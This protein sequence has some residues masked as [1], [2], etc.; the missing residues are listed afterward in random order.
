MKFPP[1]GVSSR[2]E[3]Y[4]HHNVKSDLEECED[5]MAVFSTGFTFKD[6]LSVIQPDGKLPTIPDWVSEGAII[7]VQGGTARMLDVLGK[8]SQH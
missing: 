7:G 2:H 8:V 3:V 6:V 1:E 5:C 4:W